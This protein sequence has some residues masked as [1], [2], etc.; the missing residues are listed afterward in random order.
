[1]DAGC[2][3]AKGGSQANKL[4]HPVNNVG[5]DYSL[6]SASQTDEEKMHLIQRDSQRNLLALDYVFSHLCASDLWS[7]DSVVV[8]IAGLGCNRAMD[9]WKLMCNFMNRWYNWV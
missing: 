4:Y 3:P 7:P 1:M 2:R 5:W 9:D 8:N 6:S